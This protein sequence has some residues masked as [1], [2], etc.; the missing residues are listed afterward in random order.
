MV[1]SP[2]S[3]FNHHFPWFNHHFP[4][5]ITIFLVQSPI[6]FGRVRE[7]VSRTRCRC[8][9]A[10]RTSSSTGPGLEDLEFADPDPQNIPKPL[11]FQQDYRSTIPVMNGILMGYIYIWCSVGHPPSPPHQWV[12]VDSIV[13]FFWSPPPVAC[14]GGMVLLVPPPCGLWWW[15]VGMLV[16]WYAGMLVCWYV[17]MLVC[18]Y[19]CVSVYVC[20]CVCVCVCMYVWNVR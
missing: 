2:F 12:W 4:G 19:V 17:G 3:W 7:T 1:Q 10:E 9:D 16:C 6:S 14:G 5:S 8:Q 15:Y 11:V 20:M 18:W 13:W